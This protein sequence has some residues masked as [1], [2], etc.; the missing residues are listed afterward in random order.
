MDAKEQLE[1]EIIMGMKLD[2][3]EMVNKL[4]M[5]LWRT[6]NGYEITKRDTTDIEIYDE[7]QNEKILKQFVIAKSVQGLSKR[8]IAFYGQTIR[9]FLE[10]IQ[11]KS[12]V[13]ITT[14]DIRY[15]LATKKERDKCSDVTVDNIRRNL[16]SFFKWM[17]E[18]EYI[19]KNPMLRIKRIKAEKTVKMPFSDSEIEVL[20]DVAKDDLR[21][22][23]LIE[24]LLSTGCRVGEVSGMNITDIV[25]DE[26]VVSGKGKK[27]RKVYMNAK[28]LYA[29]DKYLKSR[30]DDNPAIFVSDRKPYNRLSTQSIEI[31]IRKLGILSGIK[32]VHP[33]RFRRTTATL[34]LNR[35]MPIEQVKEMLGHEEMD[36]TLIYAQCAQENVKQSH[37]KYLH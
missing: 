32:N 27:Q 14:E 5:V 23:A 6:L 7:R 10:F 3:R 1:N 29:V 20:R 17:T 13:E 37:K 9:E 33:H 4:Q 16:S 11:E 12:L 35:G 34:A 18:E 26:I 30:N 36:T 8:T 15:F 22:T 2:D 25:G 24:T 21:M 28:A 31:R 19:I